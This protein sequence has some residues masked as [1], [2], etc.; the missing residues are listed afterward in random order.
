[1]N[2]SASLNPSVSIIT[3]VYNAKRFIE[4]TI[5]SVQAQTFTD[6][7]MI[8]VDD[9]STDGSPELIKKLSE[10]DPR[11]R[12]IVQ[13][14]SGPAI[15]RNTGLKEAKGRFICFLDADDIWLP[16]KLETQVNLMKQNKW[17]LSF[18]SYRRFRDNPEQTGRLIPVPQKVT[19]R[20]LLS[21][22]SIATLTTMVDREMTG[23]F[24]MKNEGY[25]DFILWLEILKRG[26]TGH[27]INQDLA[28]YRIVPGSV[29]SKKLRAAKWVWN[30]Y[31]KVEEL[32]LVDSIF[33]F[34]KYALKVSLKHSSF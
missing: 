2:P 13:K 33:Q 6:W 16:I 8:L 17:A 32:N 7:E 20:E 11:L 9:G 14:N 26:F 10:A 22:N 1:M 28:R 25:D 15:A 4:A 29:S 19:Y 27:G 24:F 34:C 31:R 18:S 5:K 21:H 23:P 3:P 12:L 30:I